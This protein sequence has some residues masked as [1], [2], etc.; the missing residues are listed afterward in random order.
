MTG[1]NLL[2]YVMGIDGCGAPV[3]RAP[4]KSWARAFAFAGGGEYLRTLEKLATKI[5]QSIANNS[6]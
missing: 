1:E 6:T 2:E 5:R 4:L 3:Y